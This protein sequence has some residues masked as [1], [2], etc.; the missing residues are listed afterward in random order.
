MEDV[1]QGANQHLEEAK[2]NL[3]DAKKCVQDQAQKSIDV[4][5]IKEY[6]EKHPLCVKRS[7]EVLLIHRPI[8]FI[9]FFVLFE[10][11]FTIF[12]ILHFN[13]LALVC[14][15]GL[16]WVA[17]RLLLQLVADPVEKFLFG[18]EI[19]EIPP[20]QSNHIRS[21][22]ELSDIIVEHCQTPLNLIHQLSDLFKDP[23]L[24]A[25]VTSLAIL[26]FIFI[27]S[28]SNTFLLV[29]Q[30]LLSVLFFVP[31]LILDPRVR[32]AANKA[33]E[34]AKSKAEELKDKSPSLKVDTPSDLPHVDTPKVDDLLNQ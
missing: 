11:V 28:M 6:L 14:I 29:L 1:L 34:Q 30:I 2:G 23:A 33:A 16:I 19:P 7:Q 12:R 9:I 8:A 15:V 10:L 3:E 5:Q 13:A 32:Q 22:D 24:P 20:D 18:S 21:A 17:F 25:L 31:F 27:L 4:H 26:I